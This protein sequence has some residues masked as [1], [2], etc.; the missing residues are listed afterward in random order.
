MPPGARK[1]AHHALRVMQGHTRPAVR[2]RARLA[3]L[4]PVGCRKLWRW[5]ASR[6]RV[7]C[8]PYVHARHACREFS[9]AAGHGAGCR[10]GSPEPGRRGWPSFWNQTSRRAPRPIPMSCRQRILDAMGWQNQSH[11]AQLPTKIRMKPQERPQ[12]AAHSPSAPPS[13]ST[14]VTLGTTAAKAAV[15]AAGV[16]GL[17]AVL[18]GVWGFGAKWWHDVKAARSAQ[19]EKR[20][21]DFYKE[22]V[23]GDTTMEERV[24]RAMVD[25]RDFHALLQAC[26][27]DIEAEKTVFYAVLARNIA[28]GVVPP[29]WRRHFVLA[30]KDLCVDELSCLQKAHVADQGS[31]T[32]NGLELFRSAAV[33]DPG[34]PTSPRFIWMNNL[35]SKGFVDKGALTDI[36]R[37]FVRACSDDRQLSPQAFDLKKWE[38]GRLL[39]LTYDLINDGVAR[40][41]ADLENGLQRVGKRASIVALSERDLNGLRLRY[42]GAVLLVSQDRRALENHLP[43]VRQ[44]ADKLPMIAIGL[45][46]ATLDDLNLALLEWFDS[47]LPMDSLVT[48]VLARLTTVP[49]AG[50]S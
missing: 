7:S 38:S 37:R 3:Y 29:A 42:N 43:L 17:A 31:F 40:F 44:A 41:A 49:R 20:L 34:T 33:L 19:D 10:T 30:L 48:S 28:C 8:R 26:V 18:E 9:G 14:G 46:G 36:G 4:A 45:P 22:M 24:A 6:A 1:A 16:P 13:P 2:A 50:S 23:R 15:D 5:R 39:I 25:D 21:R 12:R 11:R 32:T 27:Q 47:D 35:G